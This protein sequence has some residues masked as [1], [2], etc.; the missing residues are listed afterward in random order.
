MR[1]PLLV[2]LRQTDASCK[3][4]PDSPEFS[5]NPSFE[6]PNQ[7]ILV[8]TIVPTG[9]W[10]VVELNIGI[11]NFSPFWTFRLK[12][13]PINKSNQLVSASPSCAPSL[14]TTSPIRSAPASPHSPSPCPNPPSEAPSVSPTRLRPWSP[15]LLPPK[16]LFLA[17][18]LQETP[19]TV[20]RIKRQSMSGPGTD[21]R[22]IGVSH[23][24][25]I[26]GLWWICNP[27]GRTSGL[28][29]GVW[30]GNWR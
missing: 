27:G 21:V 1:F 17:T 10:A 5:D 16:S 13:K 9:M 20:P 4:S 25:K 11:G 30:A 23:G 19:P 8:G 24:A 26:S 7:F 2:Q 29:T 22:Y 28:G 14:P 3:L 15:S 18:T 12:K 6:S